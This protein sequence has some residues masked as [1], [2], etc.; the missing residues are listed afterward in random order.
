[1]SPTARALVIT[2]AKILLGVMN[3][4]SDGLHNEESSRIYAAHRRLMIALQFEEKNKKF[5][6]RMRQL[7]ELDEEGS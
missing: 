7:E 3:R 1:M 6:E 2:A 4:Y 5:E